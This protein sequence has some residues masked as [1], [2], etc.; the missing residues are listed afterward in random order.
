MLT[1]LYLKSH[2]WYSGRD[3]S[4]SDIDDDDAYP[5]LDDDSGDEMV[6]TCA[7]SSCLFCEQVHSNGEKVGFVW[8]IKTRVHHTPNDN[9]HQILSILSIR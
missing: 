7:P 2:D 5:G 4:D 9:G 3:W 1:K 6:S 8:L